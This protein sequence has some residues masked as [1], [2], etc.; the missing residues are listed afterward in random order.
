MKE[1]IELNL[2][3][4]ASSQ[5]RHVDLD[6]RNPQRHNQ[7]ENKGCAGSFGLGGINTQGSYLAPKR[8]HTSTT[9]KTRVIPGM[10]V[11]I[12]Y[13][14]STRGTSSFFQREGK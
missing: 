1:C 13:M 4:E 9:T 12:R 14:N 2:S 3:A 11:N 7:G 10:R 8:H 5:V 6:G